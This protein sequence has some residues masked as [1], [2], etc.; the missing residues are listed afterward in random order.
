MTYRIRL[1]RGGDLERIE[2]L[3]DARIRWIDEAG[4]RQWNVA[5]YRGTS[6]RGYY[7]R[8]LREGKLFALDDGGEAVAAAALLEEDPRWS[9]VP[10][11]ALHVHNLVSSPED[12]G[13]GREFL[14]LAGERAVALGKRALRLDCAA[15]N[16]KLNRFYENLG[17]RAAGIVEDGPYRGLRREKTDLPGCPFDVNVLL[18][19]GYETLDVFGPA[20]ILAHI[21]DYRLRW[22]SRGGGSVINAQGLR[23][24]TEPASA[25][26]PRGALLLPGGRGTRPLAGDREF[27]AMLRE[28]ADASTY[29][30]SVCT[31]SA[32][33][34][35][36]GALDGR[37]ATSNKRALA[38]ATSC[39]EKV[40]WR[41]RA[42]WT[43]DGKFYTS[44]GVSAGMD[45]ALGFVADRFGRERAA[46]IAR[47]IEYRWNDDPE[48]DPFSENSRR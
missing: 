30:L 34:A 23:V 29:C 28:L 45:M 19:E 33:L 24:L 38:W 6:P 43:T 21:G 17:F 2:A 40:L 11:P 14:R 3:V 16:T 44:S 35:G 13:A 12:R 36:C 9:D 31:G 18:F 46:E 26:D 32:L 8:M 5:N 20:E 10:L 4:I 41:D 1:A 42:R 27:L 39:G 37:E 47:Q 15:D 25:A 22:F 7:E 48:D